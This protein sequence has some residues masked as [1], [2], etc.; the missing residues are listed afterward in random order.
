MFAGEFGGSYDS[1]DV[2]RFLRDVYDTL[3]R[4][5]A[6]DALWHVSFSSEDWNGEHL[7]IL[8]RDG[9][10]RT[11]VTEVVRGHARAVDGTID[12]MQRDARAHTF[13]LEVSSG[14][15]L[16]PWLSQSLAETLPG[17]DSCRR[18][19]TANATEGPD[20][21][22]PRSTRERNARFAARGGRRWLEDPA[23]SAGVRSAW[24]YPPPGRIIAT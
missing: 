5:L 1:V 24:Y 11:F 14:G 15:S 23:R 2:S 18:A 20:E 13:V 19:R 16:P 4:T 6:H 10:E 3:D 9:S 7:D 8:Q 17:H 22:A 12:S 21:L